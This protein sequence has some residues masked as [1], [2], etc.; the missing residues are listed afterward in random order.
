[1]WMQTALTQPVTCQHCF[2][3][4]A[5]L[6]SYFSLPLCECVRA[7]WCLFNRD[8]RSHT[9]AVSIAVCVCPS[10]SDDKHSSGRVWALMSLSLAAASLLCC[11][12]QTQWWNQVYLHTREEAIFSIK[13]TGSMREKAHYPQLAPFSRSLF[14]CISRIGLSGNAALR[15]SEL[16]FFFI[17]N[18]KTH[19]LRPRFTVA[20][21]CLC[22]ASASSQ[23]HCISVFFPR[24]PSTSRCLFWTPLSL[25]TA[26]LYKPRVYNR[27]GWG[28]GALGNLSSVAVLGEACVCSGVLVHC[29]AGRVG[30][31][32]EAVLE[33]LP[34]TSISAALT[35]LA[36]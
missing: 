29:T 9:P 33:A 5:L 24:L 30:L 28:K 1:M 8:A 32:R 11:D 31:L 27:N 3:T 36:A 7:L 19:I 6:F 18:I 23:R 35:L 22:L 26:V 14:R 12:V 4:I 25:L 20:Y 15:A 21:C 17:L 13:S 16:L 10:M 34:G 2:A